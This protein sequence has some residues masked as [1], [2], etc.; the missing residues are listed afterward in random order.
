MGQIVLVTGGARSGK[1]SFAE[2][3]AARFGK[4][5]AYIATSQ[6]FRKLKLNVNLLFLMMK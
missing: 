1:S 5:I 3:Y 4:H 6:I 2:K